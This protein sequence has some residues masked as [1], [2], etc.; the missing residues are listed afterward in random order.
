[1]VQITYVVAVAFVIGAVAFVVGGGGGA[2]TFVV[3]VVVVGFKSVIDC[4]PGIFSFV[5][6]GS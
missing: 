6:T 5:Y 4:F 2:V 1:M 3:V